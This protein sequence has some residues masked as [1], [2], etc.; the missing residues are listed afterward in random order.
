MGD[1]P[2]AFMM[3][4]LIAMNQDYFQSKLEISNDGKPKQLKLKIPSKTGFT[5][6][7]RDYIKN[8]QSQTLAIPKFN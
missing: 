8:S 4:S 5:I 6:Y 3:R 7:K 1:D 2:H